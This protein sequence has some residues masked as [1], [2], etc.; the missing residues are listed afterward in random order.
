MK[1]VDVQSWLVCVSIQREVWIYP[2]CMGVLKLPFIQL[3]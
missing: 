3:Q 2:S 1:S